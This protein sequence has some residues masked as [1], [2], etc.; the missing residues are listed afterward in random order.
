MKYFEKVVT[1]T[2]SIKWAPF[3]FVINW[4]EMKRQEKTYEKILQPAQNKKK[5]S[6]HQGPSSC[7]SFVETSK[8]FPLI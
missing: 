4:A 8:C 1:Y 6:L 2:I 3:W 7:I 5:N